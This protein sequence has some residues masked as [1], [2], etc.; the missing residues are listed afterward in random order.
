MV[1]ILYWHSTVSCLY[2][3]CV[4]GGS[5][6]CFWGESPLLCLILPHHFC[7]SFWKIYLLG[8]CS[9][10]DPCQF[11]RFKHTSLTISILLDP[12]NRTNT[13]LLSVL[14]IYI[15]FLCDS[16]EFLY[17]RTFR[18]YQR[19]ILTFNTT[20]KKNIYYIWL[21]PSQDVPFALIIWYV[22]KTIYLL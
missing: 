10:P 9:G 21:G 19:C 4:F 13:L 16:N 18:D 6:P 8:F 22:A 3:M 2:Q 1:K 14:N 20:H 12:T 17:S 7:S 11:P 5:I 15:R